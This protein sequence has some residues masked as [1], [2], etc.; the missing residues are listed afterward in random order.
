MSQG[1]NVTVDVL[2]GSKCHSGRG[3]LGRNVQ[4]AFC[5]VYLF[6]Q[7]FVLKA[8]LY[9]LYMVKCVKRSESV[10]HIWVKAPP[11]SQGSGKLCCQTFCNATLFT[12]M[13]ENQN[14][15]F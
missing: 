2:I 11:P 14:P 3:E 9:V 15:H 4:A 6:H 7:A 5:L 1:Q 12:G 10:T 13:L 8:I